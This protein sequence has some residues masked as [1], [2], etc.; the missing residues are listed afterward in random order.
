MK[1]LIK[2]ILFASAL[3][4]LMQPLSAQQYLRAQ[5]KTHSSPEERIR[6]NLDKLAEELTL[7]D[8]Q[9]DEIYKLQ[10][11]AA[12]E[13]E[14]KI[15]STRK[16][17]EQ[18]KETTQNRM[19]EFLSKEQLQIFEEKLAEREEIR[20]KIKTPEGKA[21]VKVRKMQ[22]ILNLSPEQSDEIYGI[23]LD[24]AYKIEE[25]SKMKAENKAESVR[26]EIHIIRD[27]S[28]SK[29]REILTDEQL[30]TLKESG[31]IHPRPNRGKGR[32]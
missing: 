11:Q 27:E 14:Q 3:L 15:E 24:T 12:T 26:E 19:K 9:Y 20:E 18:I 10:L 17:V 21:E 28:K 13:A 2:S 4:C 6:R 30:R 32:F 25:L 29:I 8:E 7:S 22:E 5:D 16:E 31:G 1:P 23:F